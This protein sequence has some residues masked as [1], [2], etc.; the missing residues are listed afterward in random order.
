MM[1]RQ[2][3]AHVRRGLS[4]LEVII[5][6]AVF[7][8]AYIAIYQLMSLA[9]DSATELSY[10]NEATHLAQSKLA[11]IAAGVEQLSGSDD[12]PFPDP[13]GAY[14]WS[15][16]VE[17]GQETTYYNVVSVTVT[18]TFKDRTIKVTLTQMMIPPANLG[19]T[20][21]VQAT[22]L[23]SA[24]SSSSSGSGSSTTPAASS[25]TPAATTTTP[26]T[27]KPATSTSNTKQ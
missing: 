24:T 14:S 1:R 25:T 15:S 22:P 3:R 17:A 27:T 9:N 12:T 26:A 23:M 2:L 21:D 11:E 5:A 4:L 16:D 18:R 7:L 13:D 10:Q 20:Q 8:M 19:S 6:L